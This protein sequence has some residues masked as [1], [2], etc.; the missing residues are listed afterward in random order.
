MAILCRDLNLLYIQVPATGCSVVGRVLKQQFHGE[1]LGQK[2][3]DVPRLLE[4]GVLSESD[5]DQYLIVANIRNPFDRLVTYY[6]RLN[7]AWIDEYFAFRRRDL[8][9]RRQSGLV[10]EGEVPKEQ[11]RIAR[12][13][14]RKRRRVRVIQGIGF[15][16]WV[17][18]TVVRWRLRDRHSAISEPDRY[19]HHL[20][21]MLER[22]DVVL[23][24]EQLEEGL[25]AVLHRQGVAEPVRL[26]RKNLTP[27]KKAYTEYYNAVSRR[28][29]EC[30]YAHDLNRMGYTFEGVEGAASLL[31]LD[32]RE[33]GQAVA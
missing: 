7:G 17:V 15:N 28:I 11:E 13:E 1:D 25:N 22:V 4:R 9:R 31:Y 21:P 30:L 16:T 33:R 10:G 27:G 14:R 5:L 18:G 26:P 8:E 23:R 12:E 3:D 20:F 32:S 29:I 2:H 19:L 6:Q 24:Q